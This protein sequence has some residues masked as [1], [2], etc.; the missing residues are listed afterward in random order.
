M[1]EICQ[2]CGGKINMYD[3]R[4][5]EFRVANGVSRGWVVC[6][7]C[8]DKLQDMV[9][10]F[11]GE[12]PPGDEPLPPGIDA[13]EAERIRA[14]KGH[15]WVIE[16][17]PAE[18]LPFAE[19]PESNGTGWDD[20]EEEPEWSFLGC[21]GDLIMGNKST[22]NGAECGK[23]GIRAVPGLECF[24]GHGTVPAESVV[25]DEPE[26]DICSQCGTALGYVGDETP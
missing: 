2:S 18:E 8:A 10:G 12:L 4:Q 19:E 25:L 14:T 7:P 11:M 3:D 22:D 16:P 1:N 23:C 13:D 6:V 24:K 20:E 9:L 21:T 26:L 15:P 5:V 17:N